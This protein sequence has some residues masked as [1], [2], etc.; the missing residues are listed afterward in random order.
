MTTINPV[1][2]C[3]K[4]CVFA[5]YD[6]LTQTDCYL[7]YIDKYKKN[8]VEIIEAFDD[9]NEFYVINNKKC[10]GYRENKWFENRNLAESSVEEKVD[11]FRKNNS[12]NYVCVVNLKDLDIEKLTKIIEQISQVDHLPSKL[13]LI[14]YVDDDKKF[15]YN[16][17]E[18]I[19]Q[20]KMINDIPWR[21]QTMLDD[22]LTYEYILYDVAKNNKKARFVLSVQDSS[23]SI[24]DLVNYANNKVYN[25]LE[26]FYIV[27]DSND[28]I[29]LFSSTVYRHLFN[30]NENMF[31]KKDLYHKL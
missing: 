12:I 11:F 4:K 29:H 9:D 26:D 14:R 1:H 20:D 18:K 27:N 10:I 16:A 13:V 5:K 21:I 25:D 15:S 24:N 28:K 3:C 6:N 23:D 19:F 17:I 7:D 30:S 31:D 2:T 8:N 22:S